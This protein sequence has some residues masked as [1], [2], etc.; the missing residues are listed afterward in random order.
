MKI[1]NCKS[2]TLNEITKTKQKIL[3]QLKKNTEK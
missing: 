1:K 3:K 2:E